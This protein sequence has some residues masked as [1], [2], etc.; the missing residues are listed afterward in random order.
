MLAVKAH[1]LGKS[2]LTDI[3]NATKA[4]T[5]QDGKITITDFIQIKAHILGKSTIIQ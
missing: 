1:I 3:N 4:D 5:N 2:T